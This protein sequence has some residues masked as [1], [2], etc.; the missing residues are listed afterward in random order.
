MD[1]LPALNRYKWWLLLAVLVILNV[2]RFWPVKHPAQARGFPGGPPPGG[3][4]GPDAAMQARIDSL[5]DD[6]KQAVED[7]IKGN[8]D[9]FA[10]VQNLPQSDRQ[11][12]I[13]EHFAQNPPPPG[14]PFP[15]PPPGGP[16]PGGSPGPGGPGNGGGPPGGP[17]GPGGGGM[18]I[19]PPDV[20]RGMDQGLVNAMK[21]SGI[22]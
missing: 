4:P 16:A 1:I 14:M 15:G 21:S 22:Q 5:P 12:K 9:F 8:K 13:Q 10:S 17:G 20:R 6:Q 11:Q 2:V 18:H 19:P 7:W 3:F